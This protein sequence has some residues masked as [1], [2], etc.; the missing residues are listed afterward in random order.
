MKAKDIRE[1]SAEEL[2]A[3]ERQLTDELQTLLFQKHAGEAAGVGKLRSIK[4]EIA[5]VKTIVSEKQ[6][7]GGN[8]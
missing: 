4:K 8:S 2:E 1:L 5:R 3:K 6:A 7:Q